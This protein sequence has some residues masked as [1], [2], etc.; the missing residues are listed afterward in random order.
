MSNSSYDQLAGAAVKPHP[1]PGCAC[2]AVLQLLQLCCCMQ[3]ALGPTDAYTH[4]PAQ[5]CRRPCGHRYC[6]ATT[7]QVHVSCSVDAI[8]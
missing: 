1:T 7:S 4:M 8:S 2:E 3:K 6:R 5:L